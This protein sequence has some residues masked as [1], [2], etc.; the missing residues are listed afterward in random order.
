M[1]QLFVLLH[2]WTLNSQSLKHIER[3]I[4]ELSP[5]SEVFAPNLPLGMWSL[6]DPIKVTQDLER[7]IDDRIKKAKDADQN[8]DEI[9]LVGHSIGG[10]LARQL[11]VNAYR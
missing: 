1:H 8:Y 4:K 10:L 5:N 3:V 11:Y 2:A 6:S 7:L 9:V